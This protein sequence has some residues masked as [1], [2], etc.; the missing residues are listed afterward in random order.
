MQQSSELIAKLA[1]ALAKAQIELINPEKTLVGTINPQDPRQEARTFNYA[2]LASGLDIVRKT[3]GQHEIATVQTT[4]I[5]EAAQIVKLTTLLAHSS[6]EWIASDWPVCAVAETATP[7]RMGAAL[8]Y[9]RRYALFTLVGIAGEDDVDAPDLKAPT[10]QTSAQDRQNGT[11]NAASNGRENG[12]L[13]GE[14]RALQRHAK[15]HT[16]P[17]KPILGAAESAAL[18]DLLLVELNQL[19][20]TDDLALWA[21]RSLPAKNQLTTGDAGRLEAAFAAKLTTVVAPDHKQSAPSVGE[22]PPSP[23]PGSK[24]P[25]T[26][27]DRS[28]SVSIP[29]RRRSGKVQQIIDKGALALPEP[30]RLR[31]RDHLR[32]VAQHPCLVCGR[33]PCDPHHLR[34]TQSPA[35]G[36]KVSDEFTVPL[37]RGHHREIHRHGDERAWWGERGIEPVAAARDLW[38]ASHAPPRASISLMRDSPPA[39]PASTEP[40]G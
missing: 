40:T 6:G 21:K 2:S 15:T 3:L 24:S 9:A 36:R 23:S 4:A 30:R 17:S 31:D 27:P 26:A 11:G 32:Y 39:Q 25:R 1:T 28:T 16:A 10:G 18:C 22:P 33:T 8:T 7:R 14:R 29:R 20:T 5:D 38:L 12:Q 37:C 19:L 13:N 34:F 35:L